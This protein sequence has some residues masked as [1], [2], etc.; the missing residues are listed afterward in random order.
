[1]QA[2]VSKFLN[3]LADSLS[4]LRRKVVGAPGLKS[5]IS[6]GILSVQSKI[7]G[8]FILYIMI[9]FQSRNHRGFCFLADISLV[10]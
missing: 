5:H 8:V 3:R 2:V 9:L 4:H 10:L 1:M 7:S 6:D